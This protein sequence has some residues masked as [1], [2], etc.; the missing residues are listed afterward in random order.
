MVRASDYHRGSWVQ[1]PSGTWIFSESSFLPYSH[2]ISLLASPEKMQR[3]KGEK[4]G[5]G[6]DGR[7]LQTSCN[8]QA[9]MHEAHVERFRVFWVVGDCGVTVQNAF[10]VN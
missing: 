6:R 8:G 5:T 2:L 4:R 9:R 1:I 7:I 3:K 10:E